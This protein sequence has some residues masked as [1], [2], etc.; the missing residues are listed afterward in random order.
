MSEIPSDTYSG[1]GE[2]I[3]L[4]AKCNKLIPFTSSYKWTN[5]GDGSNFRLLIIDYEN[6]IIG[7]R[8]FTAAYKNTYL[9]DNNNKKAY[10]NELGSDGDLNFNTTYFY[11]NSTKLFFIVVTIYGKYKSCSY[12]SEEL[13]YKITI[14]TTTN[15]KK[16][17]YNKTRSSEDFHRLLDSSPNLKKSY[18][19]IKAKLGK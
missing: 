7:K 11:D 18:L 13:D 10:W 15:D 9:P 6:T 12:S 8:K 16:Y 17:E 19:E 4:N 14:P 5:G 3:V 1:S 2:A